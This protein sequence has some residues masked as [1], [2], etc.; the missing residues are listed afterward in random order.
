MRLEKWENWTESDKKS[1]LFSGM[2]LVVF[3]FITWISL[4]QNIADGEKDYRSCMNRDYYYI[5]RVDK[6]VYILSAN[7]PVSWLRSGYVAMGSSDVVKAIDYIIPRCG[8]GQ[9]FFVK[10]EEHKK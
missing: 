6:H 3:F 9:E 2:L 4:L 7:V 5:G 10:A 8:V 1:A